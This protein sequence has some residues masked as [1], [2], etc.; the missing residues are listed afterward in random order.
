MKCLLVIDVQKGFVSDRTSH[1]VPKIRELMKTTSDIYKIAT[2]FINVEGSG[3]TDIM[4]WKRLKTSP[5][6]DVMGEIVPLADRIVEKTT[7]TACTE[8]ILSF[9]Q[10]N[11]IKE[12]YICG[13]DTDCC[14]LKTAI[15][16]FERNIRPVV[17][18]DYCASNGGIESHNA[19]L[20]VLQRTIGINQIHTGFISSAK[21][22]G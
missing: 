5:E 18:S 15:D 16:L 13:I 1:V 20:T 9:L 10:V 17:L 6:I 3:F 19:A 21:E 7:Y 2:K 14:V 4:H 11:E 12:V 8:E 22:I